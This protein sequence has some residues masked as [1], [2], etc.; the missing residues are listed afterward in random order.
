MDNTYMKTLHLYLDPSASFSYSTAQPSLV[1]RDSPEVE[2]S[3]GQN[4]YMKT[5]HLYL[6]P[7]ASCSNSTAQPFLVL[8]ESP[9]VEIS[10]GQYVHEDSSSLP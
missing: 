10:H 7:S 4:S 3:H 1:L 2:I 8:R 6:D 5:L 9:E